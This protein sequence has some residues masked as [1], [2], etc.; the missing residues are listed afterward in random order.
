MFDGFPEVGVEEDAEHFE[1]CLAAGVQA[2]FAHVVDVVVCSFA[3]VFAYGYAAENVFVRP[4]VEHSHGF[5]APDEFQHVLLLLND[6]FLKQDSF[7][8]FSVLQP[9][10]G[11]LMEEDMN[12]MEDDDLSME[13]IVEN[14]DAVL[15][16]LIDLLVQK[17]VISEEELTSKLDE[18]ADEDDDE[19]ES[20]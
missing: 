6:D 20:A 3:D 18:L 13:D 17:G 5:E 7:L 8:W 19:S 15:H 1:M 14:N 16:T 10:G 2:C 4:D 9:A 11:I 12:T